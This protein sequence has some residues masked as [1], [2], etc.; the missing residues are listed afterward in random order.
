MTNNTA[1]NVSTKRTAVNITVVSLVIALIAKI[2]GWEINVTAEDLALLSPVLGVIFGI[3]YRVS[4]FLSAKW[5]TLGWV[6][7]GSGKEPEGMKPIGS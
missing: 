4:R 5:P 3:G 7:F 1:V 2:T 6:L